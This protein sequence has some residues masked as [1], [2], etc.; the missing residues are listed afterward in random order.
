[1]ESRNFH[2]LERLGATIALLLGISACGLAGSGCNTDTSAFVNNLSQN[3][4]GPLITEANWVDTDANGVDEGDILLVQFD[5]VVRIIARSANAF[6]FTSSQDTIGSG[7]TQ[8]QSVPGSRWIEVLLGEDPSFAATSSTLNIRSS[9]TINIEDHFGDDARPSSAFLPIADVTSTAPVLIGATFTD[10]DASG[11]QN[12]GDTILCEFSKPMAI[13]VGQTVAGNFGTPVASDSLGTSPS[14]GIFTSESGNRGVLITLGAS[15]VITLSGSFSSGTLAAGSPSGIAIAG[16]AGLTDTTASATLV[17]TGTDR[18]LALQ[19]TSFFHLNQDAN[20]FPGN[21]DAVTPDVSAKGMFGPEGVWHIDGSVTISGTTFSGVDLLFVA[22]SQNHRVLVYDGRPTGNNGSAFAVLGQADLMSNLPNRSDDTTASAAA[23]TLREPVDVCYDSTSNRLVVSDSGNHRV[24]IWTD[25]LN[26]T[27]GLY[28]LPDGAPADIVLG[29]ASFLARSANQGSATPDSRRLSTPRGLHVASG[30]LA[31]ADSGNHRVL[32]W[33][34]L[35]A[36]SNEAA[37][38]LLG[39][40]SFGS[41]SANGGGAAS[42]A[43]LRSPSDVFLG[44]SLALN[45]GTGAVVVADGGNH[46][47]L[48]YLTASPATGASADRVLGQS[49]FTA[50]SANQG[51]AV[52]AATLSGPSGVYCQANAIYVADRD[53]H[54][55]VYYDA[56]AVTNGE[57]GSAFIGQ[58]NGTSNSQ[59]QGG[60][61]AANSLAIPASVHISEATTPRFLV[62]D[63]ENHRI[64]DFA[65]VPTTTNPSA[66]L[67]QGQPGFITS[68]AK[69]HRLNHPTAA[70]ASAGKFMVADSLN[71]RIAIY[72]TTPASGDPDPDVV[73]GQANLFDTLANQGGSA[74]SA[75]TLDEPEG[76]ATD[77]T[78]LVVADTGNHRVLVF[79]SIPTSNNAAADVVLGQT[80]FTG[81]SPNAGG[82]S[83]ATLDTPVAVAIAGGRL[84]VA[85]SENHRVLIWND[86]TSL[87][88]GQAANVVVGQM[89]FTSALPNHGAGDV[90][91][92]H[93]DTP[94]GLLVT[95]GVLFVADTGNNRVVGYAPVPTGNGAAADFVIGQESL[96]DGDP[97][98]SAISLRAP[99]AMASN[100]VRLLIS[101]TGNHR[102][103]VY[104]MVPTGIGTPMNTVLGQGLFSSGNPNRGRATPDEGT[105]FG[106]RGAIFDGQDLWVSDTKNS[107][108]VRYR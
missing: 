34:T 37:S 10:A 17:T 55:V 24:L 65:T 7:A 53:N 46:R 79:N 68:M 78:R 19:G 100:G 1:M 31:V 60:T 27:T 23:D 54:R 88:I 87:A 52:A 93:L 57:A 13:P 42:A 49:S 74:P 50:T 48:V 94:S 12:V 28:D 2:P 96:F 14:L 107:R 83:G 108:L 77:G 69:G 84:F 47:V 51:G 70:A 36:V 15:P 56:T 30:Q 5:Q 106:P 8:F 58:A 45:G 40:S 62:A 26:S 16:S 21:V 86:V 39:Q 25:V 98:T 38:T 44:P 73:V 89:N 9:G 104:D 29:Q 91:E 67:E 35:P 59:N 82:I 3:T 71:N 32:L 75:T 72:N 61:P 97:G 90:R 4:S 64:L 80:G 99:M 66:S 63:S 92:E 81:A 6:A 11:T 76:V 22:D 18:D 103:A 101:D 43:T 20:L 41:G 105:L 102:I 95:L 85:D 33:S